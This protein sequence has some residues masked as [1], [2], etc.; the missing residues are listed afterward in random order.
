MRRYAALLIAVIALACTGAY[1]AVAAG[2]YTLTVVA[3]TATNLVVGTPVMMKGFNAGTIDAVAVEDG[4]ATIDISLDGD[5][6]PLHE[7]AK[8][9]VVWKALLGERLLQISD[10]PTSNAEIP[11]GG[12]LEGNNPAPVELDNVLETL[13]PATREKVAS[14]VRRLD[15]TLAGS[16]GDVNETLRTA[17]P[18]VE[19][20]GDVLRGLGTD[21]EAIKQLATQ[22]NQTTTILDA[23]NG[24]VQ[25]IVSQLGDS[26]AAMASRRDQLGQ[27]F[28][29]LPGTLDRA[30]TVLGNVPGTVDEAAPLL[31][32][33]RPATEKLRPVSANLQPLLA[34]LRPAIADLRPTLDSASELLRFTPGLLD[35]AAETVP[36]GNQAF[37]SLTPAIDFLRPY[38]PE[39]V[40]WMSNWNSAFAN[41][42]ANGHYARI[43]VQGGL[44]QLNANPGVPAPGTNRDLQP[45]PGS[46]V[47]QPWTDAFG[48]GER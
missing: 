43:Q 17:G 48:S 41:S 11:S 25:Q 24:D 22:L 31:D 8:A 10:G 13:D 29:E 23:R 44:E 38:A 32:D 37:E 9:E 15:G 36:A 28:Q 4:R 18:A 46:S 34:D 47:G 1:T 7:G 5:F 14:L 39:L 20:L 33:L 30:Q 42:D 21:G 35:S 2:S 6:A 45:A 19:A 40:G 16:E 26:S 12:R 27:V 3:P